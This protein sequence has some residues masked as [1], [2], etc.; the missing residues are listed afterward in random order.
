MKALYKLEAGHTNGETYDGTD[1]GRKVF[2]DVEHAVLG[3]MSWTALLANQKAPRGAK[4]YVAILQQEK[5]GD[6][7]EISR[8]EFPGT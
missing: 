3:A 4:H 2:T 7:Q 8:A 6:F 5:G 1:F